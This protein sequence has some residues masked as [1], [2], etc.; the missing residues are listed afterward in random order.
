MSMGLGCEK[1][2]ARGRLAVEKYRA[3]AAFA[4]FTAVLYT[5]VSVTAEGPEQRFV[6]FYLQFLEFAVDG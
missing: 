1:H 3:G 2:T 5:E 6:G 4:R